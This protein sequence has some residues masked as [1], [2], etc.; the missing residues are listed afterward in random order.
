MHTVLSFVVVP[1]NWEDILHLP[2]KKKKPTQLQSFQAVLGFFKRTSDL[3]SDQTYDRSQ[4]MNVVLLIT[5]VHNI[6][7]QN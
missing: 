3:S 6:F 4:I 2:L 5:D 7:F 1:Y